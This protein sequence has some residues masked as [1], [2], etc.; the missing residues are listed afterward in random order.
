VIVHIVG[1]LNLDI[2]LGPLDRWPSP[3]TETILPDTALRAGGAAANAALALHALGTP[4]KLHADVG[5][6]AFGDVLLAE[7]DALGNATATVSRIP[8]PTAYSVGITHIGDERT[9]FTFLGHLEKYDPTR[10]NSTLTR[11]DGD[12]LLICGYFLVPGLRGRPLER[13]LQIAA[14]HRHT[15]VL[16]TGWPS[17][18]WTGAVRE[19]LAA[20]LPNVDLVLPN[21]SELAGWTGIDGVEAALASLE[22]HGPRAV[23]KLGPEGAAW[24]DNGKLRRVASPVDRVIDT[25]GA[26]DAF[27]AGLLAALQRG[28]PLEA[29][30]EAATRTAA[31]AIATDP[32]RYPSW[33]ELGLPE[34]GRAR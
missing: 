26:G 17:E 5:D 30:V 18:G 2:I 7:L 6:D 29:S 31:F 24:L 4:L 1:N 12:I 15:F 21:A 10:L 32:R 14:E 34:L 19:E 8:A 9:F 27:N 25:V 3:G 33:A 13:T 22:A 28:H 11:T 20:L 16:D 23:V